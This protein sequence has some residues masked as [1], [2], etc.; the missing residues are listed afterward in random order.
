MQNGEEA[1]WTWRNAIFQLTE[2][3]LSRLNEMRSQGANLVTSG[4]PWQLPKALQI[5]GS[6]CLRLSWQDTHISSG[7]RSRLD[8]LS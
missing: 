2:W 6:I 3:R 7:K 8:F 5:L 1:C 4:R